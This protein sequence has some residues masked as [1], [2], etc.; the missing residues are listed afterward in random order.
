MENETNSSVHTP[1]IDKSSEAQRL[2]SKAQTIVNEIEKE[3]YQ[4]KILLDKDLEEYKESIKEFKNNALDETVELLKKLGFNIKSEMQENKQIFEATQEITPISL[5][6]ISS[7]KLSGFLYGL[8]G[9]FITAGIILY[10]SIVQLGITITTSKD[11]ILNSLKEATLF[12]S[13]LVSKNPDMAIGSGIITFIILF[14]GSLIYIIIV[15]L[16]EEANFKFAKKQFNE[17]KEYT[18]Q[19]SF[20]KAEMDRVNFH[21]KEAIKTLK[22]YEVLITEQNGTLKRILFIEGELETNT[23]YKEKSLV[24]INDVR[25]LRKRIEDF[26]ETSMSKE[27][28]LSDESIEALKVAKDEADKMLHKLYGENIKGINLEK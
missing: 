9:G 16:R 7:G 1:K 10:I 12:V 27:G 17:A 8:L 14:I 2:V 24:Q 25:S 20:C 23:D 22:L 28:K 3:T 21:I 13:T 6:D 18:D 5:K 26:I 4:C 15:S 11:E 19:K